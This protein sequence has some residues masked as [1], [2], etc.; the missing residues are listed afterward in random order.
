MNFL[1]MGFALSVLAPAQF[2]RARKEEEL[3][4]K[5]F[6]RAYTGYQKKTPM[7]FPYRFR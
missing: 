6:G 3:F 4:V 2:F 7:I 5:H 1:L